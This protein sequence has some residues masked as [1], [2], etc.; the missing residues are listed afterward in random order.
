MNVNAKALINKLKL[1]G[2]SDRGRVGLYLDK[3]VY[4]RFRTLCQREDI[5]VSQALE[6]LMKDFLES[7]IADS[8][9]K[10]KP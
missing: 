2:E 9:P 4:K 3:N 10:K 8:A 6:E 5:P 7:D 1:K